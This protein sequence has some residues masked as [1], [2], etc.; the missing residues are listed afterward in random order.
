MGVTTT[1]PDGSPVLPRQGE[2][3]EER[4]SEKMSFLSSQPSRV[5][6]PFSPP[7]L[8][9]RRCYGY[10]WHRRGVYYHSMPLARP[11]NRPCAKF[12]R[13][14]TTP[15]NP[16]TLAATTLQGDLGAPRHAVRWTPRGLAR[17]LIPIPTRS[18]CSC[19]KTG[20]GKGVCC[21]FSLSHPPLLLSFIS[22]PRPHRLPP[23]ALTWT[24]RHQRSHCPRCTGGAQCDWR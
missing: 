11:R 19:A 5:L 10:V 1:R 13:K 24:G 16:V 18:Q 15:V 7:V 21:L 8:R 9:P 2:R 23:P 14:H 20:L 4:E 3:G 6:F 17:R 22:P 12:A